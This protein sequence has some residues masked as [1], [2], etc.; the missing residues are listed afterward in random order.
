MF[1]FVFLLE[2]ITNSIVKFLVALYE[3]LSRSTLGQ[4]L[5]GCRQ[6]QRSNSILSY[7]LFSNIGNIVFGDDF[8]NP[9]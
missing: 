3:S 7:L 1:V 4:Q 5:P 9:L 2:T 6:R 8:D